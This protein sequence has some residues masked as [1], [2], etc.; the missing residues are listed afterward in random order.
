MKNGQKV[1]VSDIDGTII[2][3]SLPAQVHEFVFRHRCFLIFFLLIF[4]LACFFYFLR[5]RKKSAK[6]K[7]IKHRENGGRIVFVSATEDIFLARWI[8]GSWLKIWGVPYDRIALC[9]HNQKVREFKLGILK[10]EHCDIFLENEIPIVAYV[11]KKMI[12][13]GKKRIVNIMGKN[14]YFTIHFA[15]FDP[16]PMG[17]VTLI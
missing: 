3:L 12:Q 16:S 5:P 2:W 14:G 13:L 6:I 17:V 8:I 4:P 15:T 10:K 9:P 7:I 11:T 1:L